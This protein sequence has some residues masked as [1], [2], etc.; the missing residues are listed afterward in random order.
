MLIGAVI[1]VLMVVVFIM[2]R[3]D[4]F[5]IK[6]F[7]KISCINSQIIVGL[8]INGGV[9]DSC[10]ISSKNP[11]FKPLRFK[12]CLFLEGMEFE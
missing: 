2:Q 11:Q 9:A 4:F 7:K 12:T 10:E 6:S 1:C 8:M 3:L 5:K